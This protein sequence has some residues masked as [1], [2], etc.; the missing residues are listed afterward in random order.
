MEADPLSSV[1]LGEIAGRTPEAAAL[2][3]TRLVKRFGAVTA[4]DDVSLSVRRGEF[5]T[6]LGPS[7]SGKTTILRMIAGFER[8][9]SG[10][11]LLLGRD[12]APLSP[13]QRRIGVV[14]QHYALFP[15]MTVADNVRY[16]L[17]MHRWPRAQ[18]EDRIIE[19]LALVGLEGMGSRYTRQLSGGQQQRVALARA[20]AFKPS[21]L[22]MDEPLGALDRALRVQMEQEIRRIH[23]ESKTTIIYVTHDR[24]EAFAMSDR[25]GV[26]RNGRLIQAGN[27]VDIY[28]SPV[29]TF[30]AGFLG[31]CLQLAPD[32]V[33]EDGQG[34]AIVEVLGSRAR[35]RVG[36][37][38]TGRQAA[39]IVRP[40]RL[41]FTP[42]DG[43]LVIA[44]R[45][46]N[47][48]YLG[49]ITQ[50]GCWADGVGTI[51]ARL[52]SQ[53]GQRLQIDQR[54]ELGF[55]PEGAVLVPV[56]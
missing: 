8:S 45:I 50:V 40:T 53:D 41:H 14:F 39:L 5:F 7:G 27:P 32:A 24:E 28:E 30:V 48:M 3:I 19:M 10:Q 49:E 29:D 9:T 42:R 12:I 56:A 1:M 4:V 25:I 26:L 6:L 13:A 55:A 22:L 54:V 47:V 2:D 17:K 46:T 51:V 20:L 23:R 52:D 43:D 33:H 16:P 36:A 37:S 18:A 15:H 38:V 31:E 35:A 21:L 44:A 11:M 34:F